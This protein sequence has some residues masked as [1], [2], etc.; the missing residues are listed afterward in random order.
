MIQVNLGVPNRF[1]NTA[2]SAEIQMIFHIG[3]NNQINPLINLSIQIKR[4]VSVINSNVRSQ[5]ITIIIVIALQNAV[6]IEILHT[7][8][9]IQISFIILKFLTLQKNRTLRIHVS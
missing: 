2:V 1:G 3:F 9:T 8:I 5:I 4:V 6:L 7:T